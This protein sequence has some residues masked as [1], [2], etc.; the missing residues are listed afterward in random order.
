MRGY[1]SPITICDDCKHKPD[2][3]SGVCPIDDGPRECEWC[4]EEVTSPVNIVEEQPDPGPTKWQQD[5][6]EL[7]DYLQEADEITNIRTYSKSVDFTVGEMGEWPDRR[8]DE[9]LDVVRPSSVSLQEIHTDAEI[10]SAVEDGMM[11]R[12]TAEKVKQKSV[13]EEMK[14]HLPPGPEEHRGNINETL[15]LPDGVGVHFATGA[16]G[17]MPAPDGV[18]TPH[19]VEKRGSNGVDIDEMKTLID[20][21]ITVYND[22]YNN[23]ENIIQQKP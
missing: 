3:Q 19:I 17:G 23:R 1:D 2:G 14:I 6:S 12:E 8:N 21:I 16:L 13:F 20:G 15:E 10:E 9:H 11:S 18:V 22:I 4:G 7:V 5:R